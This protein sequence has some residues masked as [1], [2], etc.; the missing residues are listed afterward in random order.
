MIFE[1]VQSQ[2]QALRRRQLVERGAHFGRRLAQLDL[3]LGL[4]PAIVV[5]QP[6]AGRL[7]VVARLRVLAG[8]SS[9][10]TGSA[11]PPQTVQADVGDQPVQPRRELR[12]STIGAQRPQ[13]ANERFLG[14][15]GGV[16]GVVHEAHRNAVHVRLLTLDECRQRLPI[17]GL[18]SLDERSARFGHAS[19]VPVVI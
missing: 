14:H 11:A 4:R 2:G 6:F 19:L 9:D 16:G 3:L 8:S 12:L 10:S 5:G 7:G 1:V 18:R 15:I 13:Q 17:T